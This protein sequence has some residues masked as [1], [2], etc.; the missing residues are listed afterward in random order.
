M[1]P[2]RSVRGT[3]FLA[4]TFP[5]G[6]LGVTWLITMGDSTSEDSS[7]QADEEFAD[8]LVGDNQFDGTQT[9]NDVVGGAPS[10][11][12]PTLRKGKVRDESAAEARKRIVKRMQDRISEDKVR[13]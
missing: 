1:A 3:Y 12:Q 11:D 5:Y 9:S 6:Q 10:G 2:K 4:V 8:L 13:P 7:Q